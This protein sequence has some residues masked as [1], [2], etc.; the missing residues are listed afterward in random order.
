VGLAVLAYG[1]GPIQ[2][3]DDGQAGQGDV[4]EHLVDG[5]LDEGRIEGDD[6]PEARRGEAGG[7]GDR[8]LLGDAH[9]VEAAGQ[10]AL[11]RRGPRPS[12]WRR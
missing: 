12:S 11:K 6:G 7:E 10:A 1:P 4:V 5:A 3:E 9:V 8:V 2:G